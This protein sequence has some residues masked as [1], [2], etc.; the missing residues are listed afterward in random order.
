M[1]DSIVAKFFICDDEHKKLVLFFC[2]GVKC[3][4]KVGQLTNLSLL[5]T[6]V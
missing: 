5:P 6:V 3:L 2:F 1:G 4:V